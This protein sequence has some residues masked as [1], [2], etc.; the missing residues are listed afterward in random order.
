MDS[1]TDELSELLLLAAEEGE[2]KFLENVAPNQS[3]TSQKVTDPAKISVDSAAK[4]GVEKP[5]RPIEDGM[6]SSDEEDLQNFFER[7]YNEY[8]RDINLMLKKKEEARKD[9]IVGREVASSLRSSSQNAAP[10]SQAIAANKASE[11]PTARSS[12]W[13]PASKMDDVSIYTD[14]IFGIRIVQP[15][16][17][18]TVM[19]ERMV[20]R[21]AVDVRNLKTHLEQNDL[22]QDW[23]LA[24]VIVGKS[25]VQTSQKG[26][27]YVIW[28]LSDLKGEIQT[29][30][31]FLFKSAYKELWKTAQGMVIGVLNPSVFPRKDGKTSEPT[32]SID[33]HLKVMVLGKSKDYGTCKSRKKNGEMCSS[34]VN[35]NVCE[36]CVYHVKQE[37]G[38]L[39]TRSELQSATSGRGLQSLRNIVLGKSEVFYGGKSFVAEVAT[40]SKKITVKDQKRL[41]SLS[42]LHRS[43]GLH[44]GKCKAKKVE[45]HKSKRKNHLHLS[46]GTTTTTVGYAAKN[47]PASKI[48]EA[49]ESSLSQRNKDLE[50]LKLLRGTSEISTS[51]STSSQ[52]STKNRF[53]IDLSK[54]PKLSRTDFTFTLNDSSGSFGNQSAKAR[55]IELLKSKPMEKS[56]PNYIK[57][58]GTE[59]GK[60][61]LLEILPNESDES[62]Q[63]KRKLEAEVEAFKNERIQSIV[64]A[65]SSHMDLV[66]Q[67]QLN[68]QDQY[69]NK[70]EKKE[71]MEEKM[72]NTK[73]VAC[74]AVI[75]LQCKY[76][77]FSAAQRCKDE[78]H[79]LKVVDG[80][81]RFYECEDCG[82]RTV[83]LFRIPK[84]SCTNCKG[85]RW[86]RC[87]MIRDRKDVN[88]GEHLSIRGDEEM[89]LGSVS[90]KGNLNLCVAET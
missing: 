48:A 81:K 70:L 54:A 15:L 50:R 56:N 74:K 61:R 68:A 47:G 30:S 8:G 57:Y 69:F 37:Y 82:N 12:V 75:C 31:L 1:D 52:S 34:I 66:Q 11:I 43:S 3:V 19:K 6:D 78:K 76:K 45:W 32:L 27:Q 89:Y 64:N 67:H 2:L 71:A 62:A 10:K 5:F 60:K 46:L 25:S 28:K 18:S 36:Y 73:Q 22:S 83:T 84:T 90:S 44:T 7:K 63:K 72:V 41:M 4:S 33:N 77:A 14:P 35:L 55:A 17:S 88:V 49:V 23:C 65:K 39:S 38:K 58:R 87:G 80:E 59:T 16:I 85:S 53:Q 21:I 29:A 9:T 20:G 79:P 26:A 42:E 86:K 40:K 24:G 13:Q 51:P